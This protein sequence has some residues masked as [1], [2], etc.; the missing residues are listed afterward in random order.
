[1]I[2]I[3]RNY[4][5]LLSPSELKLCLLLLLMTLVSVLLE[6]A[7]FLSILPFLYVITDPSIV[8]TNKALK[9]LFEISLN[10]GFKTKHEFL[11]FLGAVILIFLTIS[12]SFK[13]FM[14]YFQHRFIEMR[15]FSLTQRL[16]ESY[17]RQPYIWFLN[18]HSSTLCKNI[19]NESHTIITRG[20]HH[21]INLMTQIMVTLLLISISIF[22]DPF[23]SIVIGILFSFA[24][25]GI[26]LMTKNII[27][28]FGNER[29]NSNE[30]LFKIINETF[31]AIKQIKISGIENIKIKSISK[32]GI[33]LARNSAYVGT[34]SSVPR[35]FLELM[36][37]GGMLTLTLYLMT[38]VG[39]IEKALPLIVLY[40][41]IG[42]KLMPALQA[43]YLSLT[44]LNYVSLPVD[45]ISKELKLLPKGNFFQ[46]KEKLLLK[47]RISLKKVFFKYPGASKNTLNNINLNI[48][49]NSFVG[50]VGATGSGKTTL[51]DIILNLLEADRGLVEVDNQPI[52]K[53]NSTQWIKSIGYVPQNIFLTDDTISANITLGG[54]DQ[55]IDQKQIEKVSKIA[56]I[57]DFILTNLNE[58]YETKIGEQ[59]I[60]LSGGQRQRIGIARA[61]YHNPKV[62]I[63]DEATSALDGFTEQLVMK[64]LKKLK[65]DITIIMITHRLRSL[66]ECDNIFLLDGGSIKAQGTF[67]ELVQSNENFKTQLS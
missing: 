47:D 59:G 63:L 16:V 1:M 27:S 46:K 39:T 8:E 19:L 10:F 5:Y 31:A 33:N 42:Y 26:F 43:I 52:N 38:R 18:R 20:L 36:V 64:E 48:L 24:Y 56:L 30:K 37:F 9:I 62:L 3:F 66:V 15:K 55:N 44:N 11:I 34:I 67:E 45:V 50:I 25:G 7:G 40:S 54:N 6:V 2:K 58:K 17:L 22:V 61:L 60:R 13:A 21:L 53:L 57:H 41:I 28:K 51:V 12:L 23:I 29:F 35:Y 65:N 14:I 49:A 4:L 32:L